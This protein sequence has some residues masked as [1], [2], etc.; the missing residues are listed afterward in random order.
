MVTS[1]IPDMGLGF[2]VAAPNIMDRPPV[3][4][5]TGVFTIELMIDML[6]YGLWL[7]A[8]CLGAFALVMYGFGN[9]DLGTG[10]NATYEGCALVFRAR[11][12]AFACLTWFSLFLAWEMIDM[13]RSFF[14][15]Q[16]GSKKYLT[17]WIHDI[18]RNKF[19][20]WAVMFGIAS[21]FP[22]LYIPVINRQVFLHTGITWEWAIVFIA[23]LL[24]FL[25]VESWKYA[26][27]FYF[28]RRDAETSAGKQLDLEHRAFE[29]Y[30]NWR[31]SS[32]ISS[33][34]VKEKTK[35][36]EDVGY[37]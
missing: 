37:F 14:R 2:E 17:Q 9:G 35:D 36:L 24:F 10:C 27:R 5:K 7:A 32:G 25:G 16:P 6:V 8:L 1:G 11:A 33:D 30:V 29:E 13:R 19:L 28:R 34:P 12:T 21:M 31:T 3:S 4:L 18:W 23:S 26:K 22:I 15:M 20:F